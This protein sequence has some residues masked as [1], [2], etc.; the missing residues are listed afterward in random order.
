MGTRRSRATLTVSSTSTPTFSSWSRRA[1]TA[2]AARTTGNPATGK[3]TRRRRVAQRR[4]RAVDVPRRRVAAERRSAHARLLCQGDW[5]RRVRRALGAAGVRRGARRPLLGA[6]DLSAPTCKTSAAGGRAGRAHLCRRP[7]RH[8]RSRR[9]E[10]G[11]GSRPHLVASAP[12]VAGLAAL[13]RQ[14]LSSTA[15]TS[16]RGRPPLPS[17][18]VGGA[19]ARA[20]HAVGDAACRWRAAARRGG[21]ARRSRRPTRARVAWTEL[22]PRALALRDAAAP[23]AMVWVLEEGGVEVRVGSAS[24]PSPPASLGA[25]RADFVDGWCVKARPTAASASSASATRRC[26]GADRELGNA[27]AGRCSSAARRRR[28][29]VGR[30]QHL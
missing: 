23:A 17:R 10:G 30:G 7:G 6:R 8:A 22:A 21:G 11:F 28:R 24:A 15:G 9:E 14:I 4:R 20:D 13:A 16:T 2:R 25:A 5:R 3:N 26:E 1:T 29:Q 19:A 18:A 27:L 12:L